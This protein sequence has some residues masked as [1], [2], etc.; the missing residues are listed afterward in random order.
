MQLSNQGVSLESF[1]QYEEI[2]LTEDQKTEALRKAREN[3]F[4][5][6]RAEE[7]KK[8]LLKSRAVPKFTHGQLR[9]YFAMQYEIDE[10]NEI[11]LHELFLYFSGDPAFL[12]DLE[13]GILLCGG[14]GV[15]KTSIMKFFMRNQIFSYRVVSCREVEQHFSEA[16]YD[17][18]DT[19]SQ[20]LPIATNSNPFGHQVIGYCFD[21]IGTESNSKHYGKEKN[22]MAEIILNRYDSKLPYTSTHLTTNLT[23]EDLK[24]TYGTR[25]TDRLR[26]MVNVIAFEP[27]TK[28]RR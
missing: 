18:V 1:S 17:A 3:E 24:S 14:V 27:N 20:N 22:M 21:D 16:G 11:I 9:D 7:Y 12:G 25:V 26:E 5:R 4:Y 8:R 15:G 19:Y 23:A 13:K 10:T 6:R 2:E 28:S